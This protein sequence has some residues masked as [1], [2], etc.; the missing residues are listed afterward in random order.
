MP[1]LEVNQVKAAATELFIHTTL[2]PVLISLWLTNQTFLLQLK[3]S[4]LWQHEEQKRT[5][6]VRCV[7][8]DLTR[9]FTRSEDDR[10]C[11]QLK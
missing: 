3:L 6:S 10:G 4:T 11:P 9:T 5:R 7:N 8:C 1:E 2:G